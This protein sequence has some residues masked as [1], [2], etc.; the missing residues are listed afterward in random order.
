[1][2]NPL[3]EWDWLALS[4]YLTP[5]SLKH[6]LVNCNTQSY[7][8]FLKMRPKIVCSMFESL[9]TFISLVNG[10]DT[11]QQEFWEHGWI[12][13]Q[14]YIPVTI[15]PNVITNERFFANR[16]EWNMVSVKLMRYYWDEMSNGLNGYC[17]DKIKT[18]GSRLICLLPGKKSVCCLCKWTMPATE[19][20]NDVQC[21]YCR[22][23]SLHPY[24]NIGLLKQTPHV[25]YNETGQRKEECD[26]IRGICNVSI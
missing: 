10:K 21:T 15:H 24:A 20:W 5:T 17:K 4:A 3:Y 1:M 16:K 11:N 2:N 22:E 8:S 25:F 13:K 23:K 7:D 14:G 19:M 9:D 6:V 18:I 12:A 26:L